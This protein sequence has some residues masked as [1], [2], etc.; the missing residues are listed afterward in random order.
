MS[1]EIGKPPFDTLENA[2]KECAMRRAEIVMWKGRCGGLKDDLRD[3][4][5]GQAISEVIAR[6]HG[7]WQPDTADA[8]A[9]TAYEIA[10][11]ML[12]ARPSPKDEDR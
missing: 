7:G 12:A 11:A 6:A 9:T 8:I 5:A 1:D 10:D 2:L 4:F 3:Y